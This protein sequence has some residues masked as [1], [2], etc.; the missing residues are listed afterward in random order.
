[1]NIPTR[2][3]EYPERQ[4]LEYM[5]D[6]TRAELINTVRGLSEAESR[7]RLVPSLTTPIGL[8]KHAAFAERKWF[9]HILG[10]LPESECDGE[11][12][13]EASFVVSDHET[14][15]D[16]IAE[17]E[18]ASN[19]ART[20]A[21]DIDLNATRGHPA[22]GT[23]SLRWIYLLMIQEFARH[24]GHSDILREQTDAARRTT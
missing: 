14:V 15:A 8:I 4:M 22:F 18:R 5:L 10:G 6:H 9:Q 11:M 19:R 12:A 7:R 1:M 23:V 17:F 13:G 21:A 20:I 2:I 3:T 16:V 24:A